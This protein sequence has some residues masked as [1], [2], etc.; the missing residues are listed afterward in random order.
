[1]FQLHDGFLVRLAQLK[2]PFPARMSLFNGLNWEKRLMKRSAIHNFQKQQ[3]RAC[4]VGEQVSFAEAL[5]QFLTP[6]VWKQAHQAWQKSHSA[7]RWSL[8]AMS[9]VLLLMT[10]GLGKSEA[11][12][13]QTARAFYVSRHQRNKRPG[14][15]WEGFQK[16]LRRLPLSVFR[17]L[18][19]GVRQQIARRWLDH[20]RIGGYVPIACDG[21]RLECPRTAELE[22]RLG[23]AGKDGSPPT[24]YLSALVLLPLGLLWSWRLGKGTASE[25]DHLTR[26]LPT[27]P[28]KSLVVGDAGYLS[29]ELYR[30][31]LQAGAAFLARMSSRAYLYT[32]D[33][34]RLKRFREGWVYYWPGYAQREGLPPI[35]ARLVRVRGQ[36]ADVWLLT[37]LD[38]DILSA[39]QVAQIYRWRWC[40]ESLFRTYKRTLDKVKL[41]HR[42]VALIHR[43]AEGSL[44]AVQLLLAMTALQH[45]STHRSP[46]RM[47]LRLRGE[48]TAGIAQLGPRQLRS[49]VEA[50]QQIHGETPN[51]TSSKT[52]RPWPRKKKTK[53]PGTPNFRT[54]TNKQK[55]LMAK[56]LSAA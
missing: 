9:W 43:E 38:R 25:H 45:K 47:L 37:S 51:R 10:W 39:G 26:L 11:E 56:I 34:I 48:V 50:L 7:S 21:S 32:E 28:E 8:K 46:R 12:R 29:Y 55:T 20:L 15:T 19:A 24:V 49:Y 17:A 36:K 35:R 44:L 23:Q 31:I 4:Q 6:R 42:T 13:F 2:K 27:L 18:A 1:V 53:P 33:N 41:Q 54:L 30:S 3:H 22:K 16:A 5:S 52:R 14:E 40:N